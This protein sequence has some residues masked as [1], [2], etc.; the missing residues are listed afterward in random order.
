[1]V[2]VGLGELN[3]ESLLSGSSLWSDFDLAAWH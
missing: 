1:M 3:V 2:A